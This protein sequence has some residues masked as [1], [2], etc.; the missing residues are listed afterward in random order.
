MKTLNNK[1][2]GIVGI[3]AIIVVLIAAGGTSTYVY[4]RDHKAKTVA[5]TSS[6]SKGISPSTSSVT[7]TKPNP[8]AGW[9]PYTL[10]N[11]KLTFRH[12]SSW[13]VS[14]TTAP[15]STQDSLTLTAAAGFTFNILDGVSN[16]GDAMNMA[17]NAPVSVTYAGQPDYLV[18]TYGTG[19]VGQGS[20]DG[21]IN[22]AML[23]TNPSDQSSLPL[24]KYAVSPNDTT[25]AANAKYILISS[26]T[27]IQL[28]LV[29]AQSSSDYKTAVLIIESMHY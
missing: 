10:K 29:Q 9:K 8:Y 7:T 12:P 24:D 14:N 5:S 23:L 21:L 6:T 13:Q 16:G 1:G 25:G 22:G 11:E 4:H 17:T 18:F 26:S 27:K 3:L 15:A 2:F 19:S 28:T 20:S